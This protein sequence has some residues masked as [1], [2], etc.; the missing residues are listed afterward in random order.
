MLPFIFSGRHSPENQTPLPPIASHSGFIGRLESRPFPTNSAS[1]P[2][3]AA[4]GS[5]KRSV[6]PLSPQSQTAAPPSRSPLF[7][8]IYSPHTSISAPSAR[9][10]RIVA[11]ISSETAAHRIRVCSSDAAAHISS[12]CTADFDGGA[13]TVPPKHF[14]FNVT[15]FSEAKLFTSLYFS[16]PA[17][18]IF[19]SSSTSVFMITQRPV[20]VGVTISMLFPLRFLSLFAASKSV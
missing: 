18:I 20:S 6:D 3:A 13:A 7:T 17:A 1:V 14:G 15:V 2:S 16:I 4:S 8:V 5:I 10:Q 11:S 9:R 19:S 12:L